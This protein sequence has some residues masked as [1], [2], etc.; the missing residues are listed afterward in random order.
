MDAQAVKEFFDSVASEWDHM[1]ATFYNAGVIDAL[2]E[3]TA[4]RPTTTTLVDV[5]TGTGFVAAGLASRAR[6]VCGVDHSPAMLTV[7]RENLDALEIDNVTLVEGALDDLPLADNSVDAAVANMVL[8]HAPEPTAMLTEMARVVRP[9]GWVAITDE[10]E[11]PY[12]WMRWEQ[13]DIWL[14][15]TDADI[16][17]FFADAHLTEYGYASLGMQ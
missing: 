17:T 14:G 5:G 4:L 13:A 9:G 10:I 16:A 6:R 1:R 3:H 8:H 2:A 7:A 11:H 12:E 15:F